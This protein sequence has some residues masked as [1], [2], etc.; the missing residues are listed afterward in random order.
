MAV[1]SADALRKSIARGDRGGVFLFD[2]EEEYLKEAA[3]QEIIEAHLDASTRDF[4]LDTLRGPGLDPETLA[5]ICQTPPL[6][7]EWRVVIVRDAQALATSARARSVVEILVARKVP[8]LAL[9]LAVQTDGKA[10]F[11]QQ[12]R[13]SARAVIFD[14]LPESELPEWLI[15]RS[16]AHGVELEPAAARALSA[17]A[18]PGLGRLVQELDKL[19]QHAGDARRI[20]RADV[21]SL[22]GFIPSE[23][24][25]DW[26]DKIGEARFADARR[27]LVPLLQAETAVGLL[28]GLGTHLLRLGLFLAGGERALGEALPGHQRFL[29]Q[30]FARQARNW[31]LSGLDAALADVMRADRLLKSASLDEQQVMEELMLRLQ[32]RHIA[33]A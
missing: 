28:I 31:S 2:G 24:K 22:V 14:M 20:T 9:V 7:A 23:N 19:M 1:I 27:G 8:G 33:A 17:T 15:A 12:L 32:G 4:N 30:R 29:A 6:M 18:G 13:R 10:K 21:Q 26:I 16:S 25:W 11:W 5:S 3:I